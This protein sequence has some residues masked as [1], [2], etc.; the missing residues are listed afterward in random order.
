MRILEVSL[1]NIKS[2]SDSHYSFSPGINVLSGPN[3]A[4]KSTIFEAIGYALFGVDARDF[5]ANIDRFL[6]IGSKRGEVRVVFE[7]AEGRRYRVSRTVGGGAKWLLAAERDGDFEVEEHGGSQETEARIAELLGLSSSRALKDQFKQIIGPFQNDFLGPFVIKSATER[8]KTFDNILG[9]DSWRRTFENTRELQREL[10]HRTEQLRSKMAD[11]REQTRPLPGLRRRKRELSTELQNIDI[12]LGKTLKEQ[13]KAESAL[14]NL[15]QQE[16]ALRKHEQILTKLAERIKSG[17]EHIADKNARVNASV[18]AAGIVQRH[19]P[20][21]QTFEAAEKQL[22]QLR[23]RQSAQRKLEKECL[24]AETQVETAIARLELEQHQV[25]EKQQQIE[26]ARKQ[27]ASEETELRNDAPLITQAA[28]LPA[29]RTELEGQQARM[30]Q[31]EGRREGLQ[32]GQEKLSEGICPFFAEP[33]LNIAGKEIEGFFEGR[34]SA[35]AMERSE[36]AGLRASLLENITIAENADRELSQRKDR[37][38]RIEK[39]RQT[40]LRDEEALSLKT[41]ALKAGQGPLEEQ[42]RSLAQQR[43]TLR[44]FDGLEQ[45]IA[46]AE[47]QRRQ[48]ASDRDQVQAFEKVALE[49]EE[50]QKAL[51]RYQ[52]KLTELEQDHKSAGETLAQLRTSYSLEIHDQLRLQQRELDKARATLEQRQQGQQQLLIDTESQIDRLRALL[53]ELAQQRREHRK[54]RRSSSLLDYLRN[55]VFKNV[56]TKLSERFRG[57]VSQRAD[58]IY[59]TIS[60][61]EEELCWAEGYQVSLTD[62]ADGQRRERSDDQLSGGQMMSAV[63][64]LRLALLQTLGARIAF[65]DEPTSNLDASRR[66]NLAQAF[67]AIDQGQDELSQHWYDQL[68]LISH[69]VAFSEI[70]NQLTELE[71]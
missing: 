63:V 7:A 49:L 22:E 34:L 71:K 65:F 68:F 1:K 5:V 55:Q 60:G 51:Q 9:I 41:A 32:E 10:G 35:M 70:T 27:L 67:R 54:L 38:A 52:Q 2:H 14:K 61:A 8:Q 44:E 57:E 58:R 31:L 24:V 23:I 4:G 3:G 47:Q 45:D 62:F 13:Q 19:L 39:D 21:K 56:S 11:R 18:E 42:K 20:G 46:L 50:H 6:R 64:S 25:L 40:L 43:L 29:L 28:K 66:E 30:G 16:Q 53:L 12:D 15:E 69:D 33:C 26:T 48:H 37:L 59:R 17:Q 36:I